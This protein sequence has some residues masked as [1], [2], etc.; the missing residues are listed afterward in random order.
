MIGPSVVVCGGLAVLLHAALCRWPTRLNVVATFLLAAVPCGLL[1]SAYLLGNYGVSIAVV[2]AIIV[3]AFACELYLFLITLVGNSVSS[4]LLFLLQG[5]ELSASQIAAAYDDGRMV[6]RR[7][8]QLVARGLLHHSAAGYLVTPRGARVV[9][10]SN[11]VR[12]FF[13]GN[14]NRSDK[15]AET[16]Q[17]GESGITSR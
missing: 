7:L 3:Y 13:H 17:W 16:Q 14:G 9:A 10:V 12:R 4:S 2:A 1:L 15:I 11:C 6:R 5:S 8:Q